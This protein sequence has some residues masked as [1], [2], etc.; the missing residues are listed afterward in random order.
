[1]LTPAEGLFGQPLIQV[2]ETDSTNSL[3][4]RMLQQ[5]PSLA[6]GVTVMAE[7]QQAGRG[8]LGRQW[9]MPEGGLACSILLRPDVSRSQLATL[10]L[11]AAVAVQQSLLPWL[12]MARIKWPNDIL[13]GEAKLCGILAESQMIEETAVVVLGIGL[14]IRPPAKG[15]PDDL[16][17]PATCLQQELITTDTAAQWLRRLLPYMQYWY[18]RWQQHGFAAVQ[19]A[20][21]RGFAHRGKSLIVVQNHHTVQGIAEGVD[22]SGALLLRCRGRLERITSGEVEQE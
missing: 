13:V 12:P 6:E 10:S 8:R 18:Q 9:L 5:Q 19:P 15:W 14:N 7:R 16:R 3:L 11:V 21:M 20:W 17:R 22:R 2:A 4:W 1:M